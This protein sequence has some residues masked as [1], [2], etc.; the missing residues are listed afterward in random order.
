MEIRLDQIGSRPFSWQETLELE[1][2]ELK[3]ESSAHGFAVTSVSCRGSVDPTH[4]GFIL[5]AR[6]RY[7]Q[8][9]DCV[10]CLAPWKG[11]VDTEI[12]LML[13]LDDASEPGEELSREDLGVVVLEDPTFDTRPMILEQVHLQSPMKP[14]CRPDCAGL[15][16][17][18]G[19]DKN[20]GP[21][22]CEPEVDP[23]WA[24]LAALRGG[25]P[26]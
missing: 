21:C 4:Q 11:D 2:D 9:L 16:S 15:C 3:A 20:Q 6:L 12:G 1:D 5:R 25:G 17:R 19:A 8:S 14:L 7:Q 18:C 22:D 24:S 26:P 23:R 10:R 13:I